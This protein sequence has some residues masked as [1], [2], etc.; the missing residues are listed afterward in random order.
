MERRYTQQAQSNVALETREDKPTKIVGY[1]SVYYDGTRDTEYELWPGA[2]ERIMPGAFDLAIGKD[3]VRGLF[4][5]NPDNL[6][7]R[8][9]AK[10]L[11][12]TSDKFGLRYVNEVAETTISRDVQEHIRRGDLQGSSFSFQVRSK[13]E[14]WI[15]EKDSDGHTFEIREITDA[16]LFDVGP[17]TFP[18]YEAT[19]TGIRSADNASEARASYEKWLEEKK[20]N[21]LQGRLASY[22]ARAIKINS[23]LI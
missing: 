6:L 21:G 8:T 9:S 18:A 11:T 14:N 15:E 7:G 5:H 23:E 4:N 16:K 20:N 12:L 10:T 2:L 22:R 19:T 17:V 3:D 1:A 13:G